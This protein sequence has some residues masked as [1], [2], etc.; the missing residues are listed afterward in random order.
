M[1]AKPVLLGL[2]TASALSMPVGAEVS[3]F[4]GA[5]QRWFYQTA[6]HVQQTDKPLAL[7]AE[8]EWYQR[9]DNNS[10]TITPYLRLDS[11]DS[12]RNSVDF[13]ELYW[14]HVGSNWEFGAG[15]S[16]VFWGVTES[17]HLVDI[18]NQT[19]AVAAVD[20]E[21][22]LGQPMLR[23]SYT[24]DAG[25]IDVFLLPGFRERTFPGEEGRLRPGL[26]IADDARYE[27][28]A[29]ENHVDI[30][31]RW[32]ETLGDWDVGLSFFKG[33][34]RDPEFI[35]INE[36]QQLQ[37]QPYYRQIQQL[38]V[39]AQL[40]TGQWLWKI[41]SL[42]REGMAKDYGAFTGGFEYTFYGVRQSFI[43]VGLIVEYSYD[44]RDEEAATT[45]QNDV[46][47]GGRISWN[48]QASSE[49]LFGLTQDCDESSHAGK[50]EANTRIGESTKVYLEAWFFQSEQLSDP[51]Y[52]FKQDSFFE[53]TL[54][55]YF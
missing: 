3:G 18:I 30:A 16:K 49:L 52:A 44:S 36:N 53:L 15:L 5:Q 4:V 8:L 50:V 31:G 26:L 32:V 25:A 27:S 17:Q 22:K 20:G 24:T 12:E 33:T 13:R 45:M 11:D 9:F 35:P 29:E 19:D 39:D 38:G 42:Y 48:D 51:L 54:E 7:T 6:A 23:Y 41:E 14:L 55:Y 1:N 2:L 43:D 10:L 37:L 40:T 28:A 46:F 34:S 21:E 47:V